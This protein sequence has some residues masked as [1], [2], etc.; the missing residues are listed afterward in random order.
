MTAGG[1]F[2]DKGFQLLHRKSIAQKFSLTNPF[3]MPIFI[4]ERVFNCSIE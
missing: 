4:V 2:E 1:T 3:L